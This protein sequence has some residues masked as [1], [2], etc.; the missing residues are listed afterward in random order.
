ML[1]H[2]GKPLGA[3]VKL[4]GY[5]IAWDAENAPLFGF[6][7]QTIVLGAAAAV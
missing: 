3:P 1:A 6:F 2:A 4:A 7:A 5:E